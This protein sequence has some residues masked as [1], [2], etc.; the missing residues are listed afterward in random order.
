MDLNNNLLRQC[1][2]VGKN[3]FWLNICDI[4]IFYYCYYYDYCQKYI[5]CFAATHHL[6]LSTSESEKAGNVGLGDQSQ[7][8]Q[9]NSTMA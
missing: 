2:K 3:L 5:T 8:V 4:P 9:W 1:G 7:I 6:K